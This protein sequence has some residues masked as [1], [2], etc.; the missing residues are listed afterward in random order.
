MLEAV[1]KA[2]LTLRL[3]QVAQHHIQLHFG[4]LPGWTVH[5][6]YVPA[7]VLTILNENNSSPWR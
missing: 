7:L 2:G 4:Y 1:L 3:D 5:N 6:P